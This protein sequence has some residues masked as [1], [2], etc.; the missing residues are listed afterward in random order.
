MMWATIP[1]GFDLGQK[2]IQQGCK[3]AASIIGKADENWIGYDLPA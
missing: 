1:S 3:V 2:L